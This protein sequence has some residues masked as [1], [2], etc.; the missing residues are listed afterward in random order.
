M[1]SVLGTM[2]E[3]RTEPARKCASRE[4]IHNNAR[5]NQKETFDPRFAKI[6]RSE[7]PSV[8]W[9]PCNLRSLPFELTRVS[10][11]MRWPKAKTSMGSASQ[12]DAPDGVARTV[13]NSHLDK[14]ASAKT[15]QSCS[16]NPCAVPREGMCWEQSRLKRT[17]ATSR[18]DDSRDES[19]SD[20]R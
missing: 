17:I 9:K 11:S 20:N 13:R 2:T 12:H 8:R 18:S 1:S 10:P 3:G 16:R 14:S 7:L 19:T 5:E 6:V 15:G 4:G